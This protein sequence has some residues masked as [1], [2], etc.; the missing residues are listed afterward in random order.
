MKPTFVHF[1]P[2]NNTERITGGTRG[3]FRR[4]PGLAWKYGLAEKL[5][6]A[7]PD[8]MLAEMTS[9]HVTG[10]RAYYRM[11]NEEISQ[12]QKAADARAKLNAQKR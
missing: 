9:T 2:S 11:Q 12:A 10:W 5:G 4:N 1:F 3:G 6:Y 8:K 7:N